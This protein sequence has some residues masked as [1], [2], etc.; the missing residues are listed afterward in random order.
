EHHELAVLD[1]DRQILDRLGRVEPLPDVVVGHTGHLPTPLVKRAA[2]S[3]V[4][5]MVTMRNGSRPRASPA[6]LTSSTAI[7]NPVVAPGRRTSAY[8]AARASSPRGRSD[9]TA[10]GQ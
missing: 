3:A 10:S 8:A 9:R 7:P 5:A 1:L 2:A 6:R 4:Y